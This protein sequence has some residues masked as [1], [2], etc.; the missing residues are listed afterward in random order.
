VTTEALVDVLARQTIIEEVI[1]LLVGWIVTH[2]AL[3]HHHVTATIAVEVETTTDAHHHLVG[4]AEITLIDMMAV[5]EAGLALHM[6][7]TP[8]SEAHLVE[9]KMTSHYP[10]ALH[11]TF[12]MFKSLLPMILIANLLNGLTSQFKH[13]V[14]VL[15]FSCWHRTCPKKLSSS[16]K[17]LKVSKL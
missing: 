8:D 13:V 17:F 15:M 1:K 6:A 7:A 14:F 2:L 12:L 3:K 9:W 16:V 10:D 4:G 11:K 5:D